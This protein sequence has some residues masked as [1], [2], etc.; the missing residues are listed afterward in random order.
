MRSAAHAARSQRFKTCAT[1]KISFKSDP[2]D[3]F[4]PYCEQLAV[5]GRTKWTQL[6]GAY[7]SFEKIASKA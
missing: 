3:V 7:P 1:C 2:K 4:Q 5:A 6:F